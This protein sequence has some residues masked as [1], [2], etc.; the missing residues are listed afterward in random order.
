MK[1]NWQQ[2]EWPSF[3][4]NGAVLTALEASFLPQ[5][6]V[7]IGSIKHLGDEDHATITIDIMAS[8]ALKASEI[9]GE[10]LN[11]DSVQS[12]SPACSANG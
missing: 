7:L 8:E 3:R 1:W 11:R 9:E 2:P 6:G 10:L 4:W 12:S 5:A